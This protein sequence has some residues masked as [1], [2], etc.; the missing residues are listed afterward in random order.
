MI[1]YT[2]LEPYIARQQ[3]HGR[4]E[5][6][7]GDYWIK[8]G[9][10]I[11]IL[12]E[13]DMTTDPTRIGEQEM[14]H[15]LRSLS[16]SEQTVRVKLKMMDRWI[17][18]HTG[19]SVL[20]RMDILWNR[21]ITVNRVFINA[22][23]YARLL[24]DARPWE[25]LI[26]VLGGMMGLRRAEIVNIRL[27]DIRNDCIRVHG[28]GHGKDGLVAFQPMPEPV[29]RELDAYRRWRD[30]LVGSAEKYLLVIPDGHGGWTGRRYLAQNVSRI[31]KKLGDRHGIE[32]TTHSLR[33]FYATNIYELT[34]HDVDLTRR[35]MRHADPRVTLDCYIKPN[36]E[37][38]NAAI[39]EL[40]SRFV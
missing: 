16:G 33:R 32:L 21:Q 15:L 34:D 12:E 29:R 25:R 11:K 23:E 30:R 38:K 13:A 1:Y 31:M 14:R 18:W 28:K 3:E 8:L 20:A 26:L 22:D 27:E 10:C 6:T 5:L 4:K 39:N 19:S 2:V 35:L 36:E 9:E 17:Q 37:K 24:K 7:I 40:A